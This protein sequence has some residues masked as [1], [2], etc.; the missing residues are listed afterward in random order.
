MRIERTDPGAVELALDLPAV[1]DE[2]LNLLLV[3][4]KAL[5]ELHHQ[6]LL[7]HHFRV[8]ELQHL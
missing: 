4:L 8:Q 5:H 6:R 1:V 2:V 3:H 7:L